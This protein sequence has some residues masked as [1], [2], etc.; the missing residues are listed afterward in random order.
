M[1]ARAADTAADSSVEPNPIAIE[2]FNNYFTSIARQMGIVLERTA[3][4]VNVKERLDFSCAIFDA[5]GRLVVNAREDSLQRVLDM[6]CW[7]EV[8]RFGGRKETPGELRAR[9]EPHAF[10]VLRGSL[11]LAR[12]EWS[13][14]GE[15]NQLNALAAIAAAEHAGVVPE[16]AA[17]ALASF[18]NVRRRLELRGEQRGIKVYDD[19]AHHPTAMRTTING[20]RRKLLGQHRV[21]RVA[22]DA[23]GGRIARPEQ[24]RQLDR[25][26]DIA[27][28]VAGLELRIAEAALDAAVEQADGPQRAQRRSLQRNA[29]ARLRP[30]RSDFHDLA[31][32]ARALETRAQRHAGHAAADDQ[33]VFCRSHGASH[34]ARGRC[35]MPRRFPI[36]SL[37]FVRV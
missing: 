14:L 17:R 13:L 23:D 25:A 33:H 6:G 37:I 31:V 20:L 7:S 28:R 11:K 27:V 15:H 18:E 24:A 8:L 26:R 3:C 4:S 12:V 36:L 29:G 16:V 30:F 19:F 21:Q 34:V 2:L 5:L 10:D 22:H 9:G 35:S 1:P 32:D